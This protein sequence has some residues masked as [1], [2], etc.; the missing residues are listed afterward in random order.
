MPRPPIREMSEAD[1]LLAK[2]FEARLNVAPEMHSFKA[3]TF[4]GAYGVDP[5]AGLHELNILFQRFFASP[6][7][8]CQGCQ[9]PYQNLSL[10]Y[11]QVK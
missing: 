7:S 8:R 1:K 4:P 10:R 3:F 9:V 2:E 6:T 11:K 5:E